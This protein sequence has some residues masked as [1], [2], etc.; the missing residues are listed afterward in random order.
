MARWFLALALVV[1]LVT[2]A[3]PSFAAE[4]FG[5]VH[6]RILRIVDGDTVE[7]DAELWPNIHYRGL[8][9]L[10]GINTAENTAKASCERE[11]AQAASKSLA[12]FV[13]REVV[14]D[15]VR[16]DKYSGRVLGS[17]SVD[18]TI[19]PGADCSRARKALFRGSPRTLVR[20]L[21]MQIENRGICLICGAKLVFMRTHTRA[22]IPV[23][24]EA[25][26]PDDY[27]YVA[28]RHISHFDECS[29][30]LPHRH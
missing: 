25:V 17:I 7:V 1:V 18:G 5:P 28:I 21:K 9:R 24:A 8:V 26:T 14:I 16:S 22:V 15:H 2:L 23:R 13:G 6:G 3:A 29:D 19:S 27:C 11:A 30:D 4:E 20:G 10:D 12:G